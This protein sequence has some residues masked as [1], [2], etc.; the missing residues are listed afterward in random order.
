MPVQVDLKAVS[1]PMVAEVHRLL[2]AHRGPGQAAGGG[3]AATA[4]GE[5]AGAGAAEAAA[6]AGAAGQGPGSGQQAK[7]VADGASGSSG[8]SKGGASGA[9]AGAAAGV[10]RD[11]GQQTHRTPSVRGVLWGSFN[12]SIQVWR[13]GSGKQLRDA[14]FLAGGRACCIAGQWQ[15]GVATAPPPALPSPGQQGHG[16]TGLPFAHTARFSRER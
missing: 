4:A 2:L 8:G 12:H 1:L 6:S 11:P 14:R 3:A 7:G 15:E 10:A 13:G 5:G 9:G 16:T